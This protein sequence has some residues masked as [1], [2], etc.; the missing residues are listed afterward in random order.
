MSPTDTIGSGKRP[1]P[2][3]DLD[4]SDAVRPAAPGLYEVTVTQDVTGLP[5]GEKDW[6]FTCEAQQFEIR[7]PQFRLNPGVVHSVHPPVNAAGGFD[8]DLAHVTLRH[9]LL[10]WERPLD[11]AAAAKAHT[12]AELTEVRQ[13]P[14]LALLLVHSGELGSDTVPLTDGVAQDLL[15]KAGTGVLLPDQQIIKDAPADVKNTACQ[16]VDLPAALF[17]QL[18]PRANELRYLAHVRHLPGNDPNISVVAT[19]RFPRVSEAGTWHAFLVSLEGHAAHLP[20]AQLAK[21]V[22]HVRLVCLH[23]WSFTSQPKAGGSFATVLNHLAQGAGPLRAAGATGGGNDAAAKQVRQRLDAGYLPC[24]YQTFSGERTTAWYRGPLTATV[25]QPPPRK[26]GEH[27]QQADDLLIYLTDQGVFDISYAAAFTLGR[28]TA[29][30]RA[31]LTAPVLSARA[32]ARTLALRL[33]AASLSQGPHRVVPTPG[34]GPGRGWLDAAQQP[35]PRR[36]T[37][38]TPAGP[39]RAVPQATAEDRRWLREALR[40]C[41][42]RQSAQTLLAD[43]LHERLTAAYATA[44]TATGARATEIVAEPAVPESVAPVARISALLADREVRTVFRR[45]LVARIGD[46]K[47]ASTTPGWAKQLDAAGELLA[48]M[49]FDHLVPQVSSTLPPESLRFFYLDADWLRA[50]EDGLLSTGLHTDLD[51]LLDAEVRRALDSAVPSAPT[52]GILIRSQLCAHWP[53][54]LIEARDDKGGRLW[55]RRNDHLASETTL[56][57][58]EGIPDTITFREPPH[59]LQLGLD[60]GQ[61]IALRSLK[62]PTGKTLKDAHDATV[63][64]PTQ[65]DITAYFRKNSVASVLSLDTDT[66]SDPSVIPDLTKALRQ[67]GQLASNEALTPAGVALQL[68]NSPWQQTFKGSL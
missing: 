4:L 19:N 38:A 32:Y 28:L 64:F 55:S 59:G 27:Y 56:I 3:G 61:K 68:L 11:P 1:E 54:V 63:E 29:L 26:A 45:E 24:A 2:I 58:F 37:K 21:D 31:D 47:D 66:A 42:L 6:E 20:P 39:G 9:Y 30:A 8:D 35:H 57:L 14:W 13:T 67:A 50:F 16:V 5:K 23:T 46:V 52:S 17:T 62:A 65:G 43:G 41:H 33:H 40:G 49:P 10:P 53:D 34:T 15:T 12:D 51:A 7:A 18:A 44:T 48:L 22:T 36:A 60:A 25:P